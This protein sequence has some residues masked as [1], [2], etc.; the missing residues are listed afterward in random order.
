MVFEFEFEAEGPITEAD[1]NAYEQQKGIVFP[2]E[3]R[4]HM[5]QWNGGGVSI[6]LN[7]LDEDGFDLALSSLLPLTNDIST[8]INVND[9]LQDVVPKGYIIIGRTRAGLDIVMCVEAGD[10]Y[11]EIKAMKETLEIFYVASSLTEY[12]NKHIIDED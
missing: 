12:F 10:N 7:Y 5:L 3:Y 1:L 11:G 4:L 6:F 8:V 2:E 9:M